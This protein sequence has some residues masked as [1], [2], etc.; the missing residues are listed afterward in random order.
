M[1]GSNFLLVLLFTLCCVSLAATE[2]GCFKMEIPMIAG[3][4]LADVVLTVV[5]VVLTYQCAV[6]RQRKTQNAQVYINMRKN[7]T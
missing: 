1:A 4:A 2:N 7:K 5:I 6:H 3:I